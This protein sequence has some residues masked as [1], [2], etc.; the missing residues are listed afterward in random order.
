MNYRFTCKI[1]TLDYM[2]DVIKWLHLIGCKAWQHNTT[3]DIYCIIPKHK[4]TEV[5]Q[6]Y[7]DN[8]GW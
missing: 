6:A 4:I 3:W 8:F 2:A 7:E 5:M 1:K